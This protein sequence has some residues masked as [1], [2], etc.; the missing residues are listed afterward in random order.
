MVSH[1][2]GTQ[3]SWMR[4]LRCVYSLPDLEPV[5]DS[6]TWPDEIAEYPCANP[7]PLTPWLFLLATCN[8]FY[9]YVYEYEGTGMF[10]AGDTLT[11]VIEG[12]RQERYFHGDNFWPVVEPVLDQQP[13]RDYFPV[14]D[15]LAINGDPSN[16]KFGLVTDI[17]DPALL[18]WLLAAENLLSGDN[19][20][21]GQLMI[22]K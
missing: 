2:E 5:F 18:E 22:R 16:P 20:L 3:R 4:Y 10:E 13:A 12:M 9:V 7:P 6:L 15:A 11:E 1:P 8:K 17:E 14:Y 19:E 21:H